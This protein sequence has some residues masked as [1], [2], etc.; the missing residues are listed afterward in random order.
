MFT[1]RSEWL[2][3]RTEYLSL[4]KTNVA[5]L[6]SSLK[7]LKQEMTDKTAGCIC[8]FYYMCNW[9]SLVGLHLPVVSCVYGIVRY[10]TDLGSSLIR[11]IKWIFDVKLKD[12]IE[13]SIG[14]IF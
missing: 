10:G 9:V 7:A 1:T 4:Q 11:F 2:Q 8:M 12:N 13:G 3:L 5:Q 14:P 6:K